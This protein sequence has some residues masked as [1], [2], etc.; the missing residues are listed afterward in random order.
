MEH[1]HLF[2]KKKPYRRRTIRVQPFRHDD[3]DLDEVGEE[4]QTRGIAVDRLVFVQATGRRL[5][6]IMDPSGFL[7]QLVVLFK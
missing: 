6:T 7:A 4:L 2:I 1:I 5:A 3:Y